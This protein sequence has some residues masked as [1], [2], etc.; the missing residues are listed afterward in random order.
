M[1]DYCIVGKRRFERVEV[2]F[3]DVEPP[4]PDGREYDVRMIVNEVEHG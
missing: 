3:R 2:P 4:R 1:M